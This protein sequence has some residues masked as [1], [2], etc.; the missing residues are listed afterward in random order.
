MET[1]EETDASESGSELED[2]EDV[3]GDEATAAGTAADA[4]AVPG[5]QAKGKKKKK[6]KKKKAKGGA[7]E[8]PAA[9]L[10]TTS[11]STAEYQL[12]DENAVPA[13]EADQRYNAA[14]A[15]L[16]RSDEDSMWVQLAHC[17]LDDKRARKLVDALSS[18]SVVIS[19]DLSYNSISDAVLQALAATLANGAAPDLISVNVAGNVATDEGKIALAALCKTRKSLQIEIEPPPRPQTNHK[20]SDALVEEPSM[21]LMWDA[22]QDGDPTSLRA[23][24]SHTAAALQQVLAALE[25][26]Q[27]IDSSSPD[28]HAIADNV[29]AAVD[30]ELQSTAVEPSLAAQ[31]HQ[32]PA[33]A[34]VLQ[35]LGV[36]AALLRM[37][38]GEQAVQDGRIVKRLL[39]CGNKH[40]DHAVFTSGALPKIAQLVFAHPLNNCLHVPACCV[41][42]AAFAPRYEDAKV[43]SSSPSPPAWEQLL[44]MDG[45]G[46]HVRLADVARDSVDLPVGKRPAH[47]GCA[48]ALAN[49]IA[50]AAK[51]DVQMRERL[52][53]QES[54]RDFVSDGG[55]LQRVSEEQQGGALGGPKPQRQS[56][57]ASA[58][59]DL[60]S[61]LNSLA[62]SS[63]GLSPRELLSIDKSGLLRG[64]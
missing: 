28:I 18:K 43:G 59:G 50:A 12:V 61:A 53:A 35:S 33:L 34:Q 15:A 58:L 21:E 32:R 57:A 46:L 37:E 64:L 6:K 4:A 54:W 39:A 19:L 20:R 3:R 45:G 62:L 27:N 63:L 17:R 7:E 11:S 31:L 51:V 9:E 10:A 40:I 5:Q 8:A 23:P 38:A 22:D 56:L 13:H 55:V 42:E 41:L 30:D 16:R 44:D 29:V 1:E 26:L 24:T 52:E 25:Q 14:L 48:M 2:E 36:F 49:A 47:L 60:G